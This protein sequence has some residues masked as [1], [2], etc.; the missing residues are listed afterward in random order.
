MLKEYNIISE[1]SKTNQLESKSVPKVGYVCSGYFNDYT[2]SEQNHT[3]K[4]DFSSL[5]NYFL[6]HHN[7]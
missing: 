3:N 2:I 1:R 6:E 7:K 5:K 4:Y